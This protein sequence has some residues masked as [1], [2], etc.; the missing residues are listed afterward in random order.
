MGKKKLIAMDLDGTALDSDGKFTEPVKE[1][2]RQAREKEHIVCFVSG[3]ADREMKPLEEMCRQADYLVLN[4]GGK[5]IRTG[6]GKVLSNQFFKKEEGEKLIR[7]CL[8]QKLTAYIVAD[9]NWYVTGYS[10]RVR[11]YTDNLGFCPI[12]VERISE[13]PAGRMEAVTVLGESDKTEEIR[14]F[15]RQSKWLRAVESEPC[16]LDVLPAS[17]DKWSGLRRLLDILDISPEEVVAVGDYDND[18]EMIREA[19]IGVAVAN[20]RDCVKAEADYITLHDNA[21]DA[22]ADVIY[23]LVLGTAHG[24]CRKSEN[25]SEKN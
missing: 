25:G 4:N 10:S 3:R 22:V 12:C 21:H 9:G 19:G 16:C 13:V 18:L 23:E 14:T 7:R 11:A 1:A 15:A 8:E 24:L 5:V 17:V 20:A 2:V 6:D